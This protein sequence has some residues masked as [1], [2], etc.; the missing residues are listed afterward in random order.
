MEKME[1]NRRLRDWEAFDRIE[2]E[3]VPRYKTSDLSG[4]E[5]RTS[6]AIRFFF[7]GN[8]VYET[9]F[10]SM[11]SALMMLPSVWLKAQEPISMEVVR[12]EKKYCDQPGCQQQDSLVK[13]F[14]KRV[15]SNE[16]WLP[17]KDMFAY[18]RRFCAKHLERGDCALEDSDRNYEVDPKELS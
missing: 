6:V 8:L 16:G 12:L 7:K 1:T 3:V 11:Q 17:D 9:S 5:W 10:T 4:D 14:L 13:R 18:F 15:A 2:L